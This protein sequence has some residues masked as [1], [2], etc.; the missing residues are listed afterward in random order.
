MLRV[1]ALL[2]AIIA[3]LPVSALSQDGAHIAPALPP[4]GAKF[5]LVM[6]E[7]LQRVPYSGRVYVVLGRAARPEPRQ[8]MTN[9]FAPAQT[10]ALDVSGIVPGAPI[11]VGGTVM[12]FP[13]PFAAI[14]PGTYW[15][16]A[17]VRRAV[18]HPS[19]G[20]GPGD[21]YSKPVE[22][23][24]DPGAAA[25]GSEIELR[26]TEQVG[27]AAFTESEDVRLVEVRSELLSAFHGRDYRVRASVC[28]PSGWADEPERRW[29]SVVMISG[30]GGTHRDIRPL[31]R[32]VADKDGKIHDCVL[33]CPD[34][35]CGTGH[36]VFADSANNG[37]WGKMLIEELLPEVDRRFRTGGPVTRHVSGISSGGWSS[38]WLTVKYP[39]Q[40]AACW[41]HV[42]DPVDFRDFQRIDLYAQGAN[43]YTDDAGARRPLARNGG[44]TM[45]WYDDFCGMEQVLGRGGQIGSFEAVF[46]PRG[47]DGQPRP[48]FD[49]D[50]GAV[51]AAT[52]KA[53]EPYDIRLVI[54]RGWRGKEGADGLAEQLA[55]KLHVYA[56]EQDNFFLEGAARRLGASLRALGSD[57]EVVVVEGMGHAFSP[58]GVAKMRA[59]LRA[60]NGAT[61]PQPDGSIPAGK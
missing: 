9:W 52:A 15:A 54:E 17:V 19:P 16:Q 37:P 40:F 50:T 32:V 46:G 30:F 7:H 23:R 31:S 28:L 53:W 41:S 2:V 55:G 44:Q 22:V 26:L 51:D 60:A 11:E 42:P 38:L 48:L 59:A 4:A 3:V 14:K 39:E 8:Q 6:D 21:L 18:D 45:I 24:F 20:Q 33:I 56:G 13:L 1:L 25:D 57:A 12:S 27:Q 36:S 29:P 61:E 10:L 49:R 5:R 58:E 35:T 34:P 47:A 43:M